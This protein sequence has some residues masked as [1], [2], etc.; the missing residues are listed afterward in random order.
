MGGECLDFHFK[1]GCVGCAPSIP[2]LKFKAL[3]PVVE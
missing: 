1:F 3:C 2:G